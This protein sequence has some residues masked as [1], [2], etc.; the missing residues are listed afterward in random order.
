LLD[1]MLCLVFFKDRES[2]IDSVVTPGLWGGMICFIFWGMILWND[3]GIVGKTGTDS[4]WVYAPQILNMYRYSS[5]G[6]DSPGV[7][8]YYILYSAPVWEAWC[9]FCNKL[10]FDY[11]DAVNLWS[12]AVFV[13]SG[14][15]PLYTFIKKREL[16]KNVLLAL[17][18]MMIPNIVADMYDLSNDVTLG[19][20]AVY[21]T[22]MSLKL[23]RDREKYNDIGLAF[24]GN[25]VIVY[26]WCL[27][28]SSYFSVEKGFNSMSRYL[29]PGL[30]ILTVVVLYELFCIISINNYYILIAALSILIV[31]LPVN[32]F[33]VHFQKSGEGWSAYNKMYEEAGIELTEDDYVL[34][35]APDSC[36]YYVFPAKSYQDEAAAGCDITPEDWTAQIISAGYDYLML[37]DY[38]GSFPETYQDMFEGGARS[39]K[40]YAMYD[41]V[42]DGD[43][44][45]FLLRKKD[46]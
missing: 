2:F 20:A 17:V 35:I 1:G 24:V 4:Y 39:I 14:F 36:I 34:C 18:V 23:Y 33:K 38:K 26:F 13:A 7:E 27:Y 42:V 46:V 9:Y 41:V 15:M 37:E 12:K 45:K 19:V 30:L 31:L 21:G 32:L 6:A 3:E 25:Q 5:L 10:W 44:V 22:I 8:N 11:S 40:K 43:R 29:G 28:L 16:V